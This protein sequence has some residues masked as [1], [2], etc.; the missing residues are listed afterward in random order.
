[1]A[2]KEY[3][4]QELAEIVKGKLIRGTTNQS[5]IRDILIDSRRL[6]SENRCVFF[7]LVSKRNNGHNYIDELYTKGI[8]HFV[9]IAL[10]KDLEKYAKANFIL[11]TNTLEA[12]QLLSIKHRTKY[13]I[14]VIG[15]TGSN[16]KTIVKEWLFQLMTDDKNIIR[17]PKS[18]NSQIGVP[19]SVWQM[20]S[21][22]ELGIFEAGISEPDEM[23]KL[24][25]IIQAEI[26]IFTN[27]GNA[28]DENFINHQQKAGEKLKLFTKVKT[29]VYC[30]DHPE[31]Q[32]VI[33]RSGILERVQPFTWSLK[34]EANLRIS[35]ITKESLQTTI[36]AE[37][38]NES[39]QIVIPFIDDA[40]IENTIH[41]WTT[42]LYLN[43]DPKLIADRM[44]RLTPIAMR[45]ELKEGINNCSIIN[46]SYN[47]DIN[48]FSIALDFLAQQKQHQQKTIIL[49]DILQSG[50]N[51][52]DLYSEIAE[53]LE[54]KG[55]HRIIGIGKS[56]SE[57]ADRFSMIKHFFSSTEEFL[58]KF[59][60]ASFS[61]ESILLKGARLFEFEQISKALQQKAH[62]TV[63]EIN[64]N[65][66]VN[67]LNFYKSG[68]KNPQTKIM[69]MVKAFSYGS[70]SF[71]I[72]NVLQFHN[73]DYLAVAYTDEGVEL[74]KAGIHLPIMVMNP[75]EQSFDSII[76]H[77]LE[78]EI[79]SFRI[80]DLLE[81]AI[82]KNIIPS[83][84]P[85]KI[86]LKLDTGMHRLGF[87]ESEI[88][89]LIERLNQ[90]SS[91]YLQSIFSHLAASE[92]SEHD[93]FTKHQINLF[94]RLSDRIIKQADD[95]PIL[96]HILNSA[97]INRF[98]DAQF[99]MVRL[100]IGMYGIA[101]DQNEANEL[102]D[103]TR[104]RSTISQIKKLGTEETIGYNRM[105][106]LSTESRIAV[107]PIGYADGLRRAFGNGKGNLIVNGQ[108]APIIGNVCMDM[109][110]ID[111]THIHAKEGDEV[112]IFGPE[113]SITKLAK[114][115]NTIPYE[116]LSGI[117]RRVK[118]IYYQE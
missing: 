90:H 100:G 27:I 94:K 110:M 53:L 95:H 17:S 23:E 109:C 96:L 104:L 24:Q 45:L 60:F 71:E 107:I 118:R 56:I 44:L 37:F 117:S 58:N 46:D 52:V 57:H 55:I 13:D 20:D 19:L 1:M 28:H 112:I 92:N 68:L 22:H 49:S 106:G 65:S 70:G 85:I 26:G 35:D 79:Y 59:S 93:E 102:E 72:A 36:K 33:I 77:N 2:I 63:L 32:G 61:N 86:H 54:K 16:G 88:D 3:S 111:V 108:S 30:A 82:K 31:I 91:I 76:K 40:S 34:Q 48:S 75:D 29:L 38:K 15:I 6:I 97:G 9:V 5:K 7:A 89:E 83:N 116:I 42:L 51:E 11:V 74:R 66:L 25:H 105:G 64:L 73:V 50:Q 114:S 69:A 98:P 67:N 78:P 47:S 103:V 101:S 12:L 41:C 84:K 21:Q 62:E 99:D 80:L 43:Y 14:P 18:Y 87:L 8:R 115:V 4:I 81:K 10:P 113:Q 39:I